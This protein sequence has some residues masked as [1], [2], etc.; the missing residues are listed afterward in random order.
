[1]GIKVPPEWPEIDDTKT[2]KVTVDG[3]Q[4]GG[5]PNDCSMNFVAQVTCCKLGNLLNAYIDN[6]LE[7]IGGNECCVIS[8]FTAQRIKAIEGPYDTFVL[9]QADL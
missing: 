6:D 9:C 2:Y 8:G 1:M 4:G 3:F 7:C 5:P